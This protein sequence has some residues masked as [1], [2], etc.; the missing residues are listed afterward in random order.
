MSTKKITA[1]LIITT[2]AVW[3]LYDIYA[4]VNAGAPGTESVAIRDFG[5]HHPF[6]PWGIG[7]VMGHFF[8]NV[9]KPAP[10]WYTTVILPIV[11]SVVLA[12]DLGH[13]LPYMVSL[14]PFGVGVV[15][16]RLLWPQ[17]QVQ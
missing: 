4:V 5:Q 16:G 2:I 6:L 7:T 3:I 8:W 9:K 1:A 10:S 12:F 17:K 13:I 15:S 11:G 14:L